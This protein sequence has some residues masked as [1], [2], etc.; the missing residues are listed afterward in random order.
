MAEGLKQEELLLNNRR[1]II[2][3]I[4]PRRYAEIQHIIQD[5][6]RIQQLGFNAIWINPIQVANAT[7]YHGDSRASSLYAMTD[8]DQYAAFL[9]DCTD[10]SLIELTQRAKHLGL[11]PIFD[12]VLCH[13]GSDANICQSHPEYFNFEE[14]DYPDIVLFDYSSEE[15]FLHIFETFWKSYIDKYIR[16]GFTGV[17]VDQAKPNK[18]PPFVQKHVYDYLR[19]KMNNA[20]IIFAEVLFDNADVNQVSKEL[21]PVEI[22]HI[23]N[24]MYFKQ[25]DAKARSDGTWNKGNSTLHEIGCKTSACQG[26]GGS[27]GF[28][29]SHDGLTLACRV[30]ERDALRSKRLKFPMKF[31][32][33]AIVKQLKSTTNISN[34][35]AK[36]IVNENYAHNLTTSYCVEHIKSFGNEEKDNHLQKIKEKITMVAFTSDGGWYLMC[37]DEF[38]CT[39]HCSV[40]LENYTGGTDFENRW[41]GEYDISQFIFEINNVIKQLPPVNIGEWCEHFYDEEHPQAFIVLKHFKDFPSCLVKP[42][43]I[44]KIC[45]RSGEPCTDIEVL[46][47]ATTIDNTPS[48]SITN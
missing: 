10:D 15:K 36:K 48:I 8:T 31:R 22:T 27:I 39:S 2:Y 37:G 35:I 1:L 18:L 24:S 40:F 7:P 6:P 33:R 3:N 30:I 13:M 14:K 41:G 46:C 12:L 4:F 21:L 47:I 42:E 25:S 29:G 9:P 16:L 19:N 23:T 45:D 20:C 43:L 17:R 5:L 28:A 32:K 11:I 26:R 38:G 44:G 34:S